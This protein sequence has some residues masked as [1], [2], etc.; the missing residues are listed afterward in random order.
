MLYCNNP[1]KLVIARGLKDY[2]VVDTGDV[3]VICP[4][5]DQTLKDTSRE[6][7]RPEFEEYR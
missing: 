1:R 4:K 3:L 5:D 7:T 2:L 6:M